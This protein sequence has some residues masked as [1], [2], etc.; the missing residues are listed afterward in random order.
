MCLKLA[1][2]FASHGKKLS[3]AMAW[4]CKVTKLNLTNEQAPWSF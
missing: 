3:F 2:F 4:P 1:N